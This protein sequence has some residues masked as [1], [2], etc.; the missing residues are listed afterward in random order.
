M[1]L[2]AGTGIWVRSQSGP[3]R[4]ICRGRL[5]HVRGSDLVLMVGTLHGSPALLMSRQ[6]EKS[7]WEGDVGTFVT[8]I[9]YLFD[10]NGEARGNVNVAK[11]T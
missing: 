10:K 3:L 5:N 8:E 11:P 6:S 4:A 2:K 1:M 9:L 7:P